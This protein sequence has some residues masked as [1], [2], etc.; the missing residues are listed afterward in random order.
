MSES[1]VASTL[2]EFAAVATPLPEQSTSLLQSYT[3]IAKSYLRARFTQHVAESPGCACLRSGLVSHEFLVQQLLY[4]I[5]RSESSLVDS[6]VYADPC[7]LSS[8]IKRMTGASV[9]LIG[10]GF[11]GTCLKYITSS[12]LLQ[13]VPTKTCLLLL[14]VL[15]HDAHNSLRWAFQ[16][17]LGG[18]T[19]TLKNLFVGTRAYRHSMLQ[20]ASNLVAWLA[21]V[22]EGE[23]SCALPS[24]SDLR[25]MHSLL[26]LSG[27]VLETSCDLRVWSVDRSKLCVLRSKL[28]SSTFVEDLSTALF[29]CWRFPSFVAGA[30]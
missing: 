23:D 2:H 12:L 3:E 27:T 9:R 4:T 13:R 25:K 21:L 18:E 28:E 20:C 14:G 26:G 1:S 16:N 10:M 15:A 6:L 24:A 11:Q 30:P 5:M 22:L 17:V 8:S 7:P 29:A 19:D